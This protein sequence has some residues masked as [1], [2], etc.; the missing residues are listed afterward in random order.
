MAKLAIW[1]LGAA[2]VLIVALGLLV[3]M[4]L[5]ALLVISG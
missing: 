5:Q 1:P 2:I 4:I 3:R